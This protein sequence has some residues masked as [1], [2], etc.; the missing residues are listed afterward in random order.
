MYC[1]IRSQFI[2]IRLTGSAFVRNCSAQK[3]TL[4]SGKYV[5]SRASTS[6]SMV[7]ASVMMSLILCGE[8][9][10][11]S[12]VNR[13]QAKSQCRPS[14]LL[15]SSLEKVNPGIRP[16]R[17]SKGVIFY[18]HTTAING[19]NI[20]VCCVGIRVQYIHHRVDLCCPYTY[21]ITCHTHPPL[22]INM[23]HTPRHSP[24]L[25]PEDGGKRTRE[26]DSLNRCKCNDALSETGR[27]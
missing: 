23:L 15:I 11:T 13:R 2:P 20:T 14:S 3:T 7:T 8:G 19:V 25:E 21:I 10:W 17:M 12:L 24:L 27:L 1:F 22:A 26:E 5:E 9:L 4:E 16:L 6:C 18:M